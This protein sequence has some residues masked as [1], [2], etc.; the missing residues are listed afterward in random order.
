MSEIE[1]EEV[2]PSIDLLIAIRK[3]TRSNVGKDPSRYGFEDVNNDGSV[4]DIANYVS[5][6]SLSPA[7]KA[8]LASL[9]VVAV[10]RDW[11]E[12]NQNPK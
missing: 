1:G 11:R 6:E 4:N 7:Y 9:Q 8:F 5:Y 10:P 3:G 2:D 12:A